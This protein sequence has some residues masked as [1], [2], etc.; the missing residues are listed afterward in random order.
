MSIMHCNKCNEY[1]DT[2]QE[3]F[4][5]ETLICERCEDGKIRPKRKACID[6]DNDGH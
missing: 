2:D 5:F 3:E 6:A 4:N 1:I